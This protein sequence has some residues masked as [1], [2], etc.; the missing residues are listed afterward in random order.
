MRVRGSICTV[1]QIREEAELHNPNYD[2]DLP[3]AGKDLRTDDDR[4]SDHTC[5]PVEASLQEG[6]F[7]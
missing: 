6:L 5:S 3:A 7:Q 1:L 2:G 4:S